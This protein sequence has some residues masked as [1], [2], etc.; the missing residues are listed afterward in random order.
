MIHD[1]PETSTAELSAACES[2]KLQV[3]RMID[4]GT[5]EWP[6]MKARVSLKS[7]GWS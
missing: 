5:I 3:R 6:A 2:L 1:L 7:R 4:E